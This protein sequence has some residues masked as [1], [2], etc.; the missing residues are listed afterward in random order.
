MQT[1]LGASFL[2]INF[3]FL[4]KQ[5][6]KEPSESHNDPLLIDTFIL[7]WLAEE[8]VPQACTK[9]CISGERL[10]LV[11]AGALGVGEEPC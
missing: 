7:K 8:G 11:G 9:V 5:S 4:R 1:E 10:L 6:L 3:T 2:R